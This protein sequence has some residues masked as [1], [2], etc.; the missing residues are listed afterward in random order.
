[1]QTETPFSDAIKT[2]YPEQIV[3][4]IARDAQGKYNPITLGWT[5][6]CSSQ[7]PMLAIA[8]GKGKHSTGAIEHSG[9]FVIAFPAAD[10]ADEVMVFGTTSGRDTDKLA[11]SG[12]PTLPASC[13]DSVLLTG[14][15]ANFECELVSQMETG[16]HVI[17]IGKVVASHTNTGEKTLNRLYTVGPGWILGG[18]AR[19]GGS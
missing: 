3:V 7:P 8:V 16:D 15:V 13:I 1:M 17:Y 10:Q 12:S 5:M 18:L 11:V 19:Q 9:Q 6:I 2:K 4:A 14:A